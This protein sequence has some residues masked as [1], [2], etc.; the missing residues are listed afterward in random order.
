MGVGDDGDGHE[1]E[2]SG[3]VARALAGG[4]RDE[5][6]DGGRG[7]TGAF[8]PG[9]SHRPAAPPATKSLRAINCCSNSLFSIHIFSNTYMV[10][11]IIISYLGEL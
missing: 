8:R 5:D 9:L 1:D 3:R 11:S 2:C 4:G 6:E 10:Q 7:G